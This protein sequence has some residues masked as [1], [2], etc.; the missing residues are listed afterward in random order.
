VVPKIAGFVA[1]ARFLGLVE[2]PVL[3]VPFDASTTLIPLTLT[4]IAAVTMTLGNLLALVQDNLRRMLAYSGIAHGGYMLIGILVAC[5]VPTTERGANQSGLDA[6]LYYLVAYALMTIGML[7][8]MSAL[9]RAQQPIE[10][11]DDLTGLGTARPW[12]AASLSVSLVSLIGLPLTAGFVGKFLLFVS[13]FD[14]P[15]DTGLKNLL[16]VLVIVAA[17]NAAI[18]AVYYLRVLGVMY[19][20]S[21]LS[22][23]TEQ[24]AFKPALLVALFCALGSVIL[25]VYPQPL[26][27]LTRQVAPVSAVPAPT[28][29]AR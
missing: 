5:T 1:L 28:T 21:P 4:V 13:A 23:E 25:G 15:T 18:A 29:D 26:R 9:T 27:N 3:A 14:V 17:V 20:R 7:A 6:L 24:T 16:Q 19:L 12:S 8:V 11:I 2:Y 22:T 10:T